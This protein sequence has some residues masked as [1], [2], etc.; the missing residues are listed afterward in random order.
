M[1]RCHDPLIQPHYPRRN[2]YG[3]I[4]RKV[5]LNGQQGCDAPLHQKSLESAVGIVQ[6]GGLGVSLTLGVHGDGSDLLIVQGTVI[7]GSTGGSD[8]VNHVHTGG[9]LAECSILQI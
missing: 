5:R 6:L 9:H 4:F 1:V 7:T 2:Q 3:P 8:G